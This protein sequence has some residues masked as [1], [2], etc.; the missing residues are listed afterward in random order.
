MT[1]SVTMTFHRLIPISLKSFSTSSNHRV[2]QGWRTIDIHGTRNNIMGTP[3]IKMTC[4]LF[5]NSK[6]HY[7]V[8]RTN[9]KWHIDPKKL[10]APGVGGLPLRLVP[11][12]LD[13]VTFL[14]GKASTYL[15][16]KPN[17]LKR[18]AFIVF[19]ISTRCSPE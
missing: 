16:R 13:K 3:T 11:S 12:I 15:H 4:T 18:V 10:A 9:K 2:G 1:P 7:E 19:T 5:Q 6:V 8:L 17:H 14:V